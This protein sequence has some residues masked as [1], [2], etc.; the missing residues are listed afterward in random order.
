MEGCYPVLLGGESVGKVT[1]EPQGL[2]HH[3]SC[4]CQL[5]G[6]VMEELHAVWDGGSIKLGLLVPMADRF[7]LDT[8]ISTKLDSGKPIR[9]CL[10]PRHAKLEGQFHPVLPEEPFA[11]LQRLERAFLVMQNGRQGI[12]FSDEK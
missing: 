5:S 2:Y 9:F 11:F 6:E 8:R 10:R 1:V 4:R 7:G 3:F 12:V